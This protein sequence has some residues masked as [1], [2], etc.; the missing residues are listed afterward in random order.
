MSTVR[1]LS[2]GLTAAT[3][4]ASLAGAGVFLCPVAAQKNYGPGVT[5]TEIKIGNV[6]PYTG[7]SHDFGAV[8]KAEASYF[9]MINDKGGVNGRMINFISRDS[10]SSPA[11]IA[12]LARRQVEEDHVLLIFSTFGTEGN[13]AMRQWMNDHKVPQ[14]LLDSASAKFDD[15]AHFPW[16]M[17]FFT[18]FRQEGR[19]YAK[20]VMQEKPGAKI[21]ILYQNDETGREYLE[22]VHSYLGDRA[23][24]TIVKEIPYNV[25]DPS[26][27]PRVGELKD[28][29]ADV[30][31]NFSVGVFT[32]RT[33]RAAYDMDWRPMQFIPNASLSVAAFIEPAGLEKAKGII[34]NARSKGWWGSAARYDPDVREYVQWMYKYNPGAPMKDQNYVAGYERAQVLVEI[35]KECGDDLTRENVMRKATHL[36]MELG[37]LRP[38]ITIS[39]SPTDYQPIKKLFLI[40]FD[41]NEWAGIGP[42]TTE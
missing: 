2:F 19:A 36:S 20:Y 35:L 40:Q 4:V 11:N 24:R 34:C 9:Q 12:D 32:T 22:G 42:V 41:G 30:F 38:G 18:T 26:I 8:G 28:S 14:I 3:I 23:A 21:A 10:E 15:P 29:G 5:D 33:I 17:G 25:Q 39:T 13:L 37:I 27:E 6:M 31:L 7:L 16:T 1:K